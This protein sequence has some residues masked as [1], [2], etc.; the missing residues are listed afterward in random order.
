MRIFG[1]ILIAAGI[2][3]LIFRGFSFTQEKKVLDIGPL[4]LNKKE[5][6][7]VG[8]PMIAGAVAIAAGAFIVI[9]KKNK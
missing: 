6:R 3:M 7:T 4:E 8:W 1:I 2:L 5:T 9:G